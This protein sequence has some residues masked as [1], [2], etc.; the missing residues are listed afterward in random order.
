MHSSTTTLSIGKRGKQTLFKWT[1]PWRPYE[2]KKQKPLQ[3]TSASLYDRKPQFPIGLGSKL[4]AGRQR[5]LSQTL[6]SVKVGR[7]SL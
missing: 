4:T 5:N 3:Y 7:L 6:I 1:K 2:L